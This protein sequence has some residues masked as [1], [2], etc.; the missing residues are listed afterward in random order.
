[1]E[2]HLRSPSNYTYSV[3][4]KIEQNE[5]LIPQQID[6]MAQDAQLTQHIKLILYTIDI[7]CNN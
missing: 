3:H 5:E 2:I 7:I 6:F 1:M 4:A